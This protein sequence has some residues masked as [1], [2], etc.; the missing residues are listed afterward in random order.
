MMSISK[1]LV[2]LAAG[3]TLLASAQPARA[4]DNY[5]GQ[6]ILVGFGYC[7]MYTLE[8]NGQLLA[9]QTYT[10]LFSLFGTTYG[11]D[12]KQ[13]FALPDLRGRAPVSQG[14]APGLQD[15][16]QGEVGGAETVTLTAGQLPSHSHTGRVMATT[17]PATVDDPTGAVLADFPAGAKI[18]N[19][20]FSPAVDM[21]PGTV[22]TDP[23]GG[24]QPVQVR[25]PYLAIRYCIVSGGIYP[26]RPG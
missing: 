16:Q 6:V 14:Q 18:Y 25:S 9:L 8:A 1:Y 26:P 2:A 15:Y 24:N 4:Q 10:A 19:P 17:A 12:G 5:A 20:D 7:P 3:T 11:G 23:A 13:T 22:A 21:A